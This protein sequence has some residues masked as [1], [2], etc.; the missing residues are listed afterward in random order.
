MKITDIKPRPC[1]VCGSVD[2]D[3]LHRLRLVLFDNHPLDH[4]CVTVVCNYCGMGFNRETLQPEAYNR[5]YAELSKYLV[6]T[7]ATS[8][9]PRL[10]EC[11]EILANLLPRDAALL[12]AGCG[13]GGVLAALRQ[14]GFT[15]LAGLDPTPECIRIIRDEL[16]IDARVGTLD[17]NPFPPATFDLV[18]ST[19]VFE[20]LINPGDDVDRMAALLK[21]EGMAFILV[22]DATR[23]EEF[24]VSPFQDVN[25]E[26]INHFSPNTLDQLF[27]ARGW[28]RLDAGNAV[29]TLTPTWQSTLIWGLYRKGGT[30]R[31]SVDADQALRK[32]LADYFSKSEKM[33]VDMMARLQDDLEGVDEVMLWGAGHLTSLLLAHGGLKGKRVKAIID[34]NPNFAGRTLSGAAVGGYELRGDFGGPVVVATVREQDSVVSKIESL[35]W[36]N[37]IVRLRAQ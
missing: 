21:P 14:R 23:Y 32:G 19:V 8:P 1:P 11:T 10:P 13:S 4:D 33:L 3:T 6:S 2:A 27:E 16:G 37:R 36:P 34:S 26:H 12:D 18:L 7:S 17:E 20:H 15:N 5:Y 35:G 22:P 31:Y 28:E 25:V 30:A 29:F 9:V 24:M